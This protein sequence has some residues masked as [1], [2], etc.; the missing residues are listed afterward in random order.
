MAS[1]QK[2]GSSYRIIVSIGYDK[3]EQKRF[4]K[5]WKP[6]PGMTQKQVEKELNRI[7]TLFEEECTSCREFDNQINFRGFSS[8]WI[9]EHAQKN[10]KASTVQGYKA[11]LP[12]INEAIGDIKLL[13]LKPRHI[14]ELMNNLGEEGIRIDKKYICDIDIDEKIKERNMT[15]RQ[16]ARLAD[17]SIATLYQ[18]RTK[19]P[20]AETT[21]TKVCD[22]LGLIP[23]TVFKPK[24]EHTISKQTQLHH[25]RLISSILTSAVYWQLIPNN[26]CKRVQPP[27]VNRKEAK[28]L[29][30]EETKRLLIYLNSEELAFRTLVKL[31]LHT[32]MRR[33]EAYGLKWDDVDMDEGCIQIKRALTY[34]PETGIIFDTPKTQFSIRVIR[35]S[36]GIIEL[37]REYKAW[38]DHQKE[39]LQDKWVDNN[40]IFTKWNGMPEQPV[41]A[42]SR[43]RV[44]INQ[45]D[46]PPIS[47]HSLRHTNAS[48]LINADVDLK[49]VSQRLGHARLS[50]TLDIYT[51]AIPSANEKAADKMEQILSDQ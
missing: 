41:R 28:Y 17:I 30:D 19:V 44:F 49:T 48:L 13:E 47:L 3:G 9:K 36:H 51:H 37:L 33:G 2:R 31:L 21:M 45:T 12:R 35:I 26:P 6:M 5:S 14:M 25:F 4:S 15:L 42:T 7:A 39:I 11:A 22:A 23:N 20:I 27:K 16:F 43:F 50:T 8:R 40:L 29:N 10:L 18:A 1:I 46:L 32:G 34:T 24:N 38:Q